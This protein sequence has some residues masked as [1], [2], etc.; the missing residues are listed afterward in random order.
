L[1]VASQT[2]IPNEKAWVARLRAAVRGV[3]GDN[4]AE[5]GENS[6]S[7]DIWGHLAKFAEC[8]IGWGRLRMAVDG[9]EH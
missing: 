3:E 2:F 7:G 1:G 8:F 9:D 4:K 6:K 5:I